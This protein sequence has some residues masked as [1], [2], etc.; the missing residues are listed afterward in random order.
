[1]LKIQ[2]C[3]SYFSLSYY[4][5][6]LFF[7]LQF[8][9]FFHFILPVTPCALLSHPSLPSYF[10]V[11]SSYPPTHPTPHPYLTSP[12]PSVP[13]HPVHIHTSLP[14][15]SLNLNVT[16]HSLHHILFPRRHTL[17]LSL[18]A[19]S[20]LPPLPSTTPSLCSTNMSSHVAISCHYD[21]GDVIHK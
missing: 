11:I 3:C 6:Y 4:H 21:S 13:H 15:T 5:Y 18:Q 17:S 9:F 12:F 20:P 10:Y 19:T 8:F 16:S 2:I 1:M 7:Q 14:V